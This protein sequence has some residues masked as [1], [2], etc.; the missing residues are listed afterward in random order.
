MSYLSVSFFFCPNHKTAQLLASALTYLIVLKAEAD[1]A[2]MLQK[3][4][5]FFVL[6]SAFRVSI[7]EIQQGVSS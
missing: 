5:R 2:K 6:P 7:T 1:S 4:K 3:E